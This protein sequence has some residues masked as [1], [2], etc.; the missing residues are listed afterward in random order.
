MNARNGESANGFPLRIAPTVNA[1]VENISPAVA[2]FGSS[3]R[4]S[5]QG[6]FAPR[7]Q[8]VLR[9]GEI[10]VPATRV[11]PAGDWF[12]V[13]VPATPANSDNNYG[14]GARDVT[15]T[16]WGV[17]A[18]VRVREVPDVRGLPLRTAVRALH[19]AGFRVQLATG[20]LGATTPPAGTPVRTGSV[21][22]LSRP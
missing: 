5:G 6:F 4:V 14:A 22:R 11:S 21:V 16:V 7:D 13:V 20:A 9:V 19:H 1:V 17:P 2:E 18:Q 3:I 12:S 10:A 8:I 15:V